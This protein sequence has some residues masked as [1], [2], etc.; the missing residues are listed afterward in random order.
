MNLLRMIRNPHAV[1]KLAPK[2]DKVWGKLAAPI[3]ASDNDAIIRAMSLTAHLEQQIT[4]DC[5]MSP[6]MVKAWHNSRLTPDQ[7]R[8]VIRNFEGTT[9]NLKPNN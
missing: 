1:Q 9:W 3:Y 7:A 8:D 6:E 4:S 2:R 5:D